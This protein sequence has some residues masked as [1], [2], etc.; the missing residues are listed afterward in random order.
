MSV[1]FE[2]DID[3]P[4]EEMEFSRKRMEARLNRRYFDR[5][6]INYCVVPRYFA[7]IFSLPYLDYFK[8]VETQY[9]WQLQ[10]VRYQIENLPSDFC[11]GPVI[12][13]HPYFDNVIPPSAYGAEIGWTEGSP[14]RAVPVIHTLEGMERYEPPPPEHGKARL[15]GSGPR[16]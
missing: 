8:D 9:Y 2:I 3:Y 16:C 4:L 13:V 7:P 11:T 1:R 10:F 15:A 12:A 14:P 6:P 5:I